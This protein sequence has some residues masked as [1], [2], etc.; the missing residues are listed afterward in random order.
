M[1]LRGGRDGA[2]PRIFLAFS[3][4]VLIR[5]NNNANR[6]PV[7]ELMHPGIADSL[8][9]RPHVARELFSGSQN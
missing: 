2:I 8:A 5:L 4:P 9:Q 1:G 7:I 3:P 6:N